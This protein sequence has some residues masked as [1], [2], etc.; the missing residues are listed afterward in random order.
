[1][2]RSPDGEERIM[3]NKKS[4]NRRQQSQQGGMSDRGGR[5]QSQQPSRGTDR[6]QSGSRSDS[7]RSQS[8]IS[9][10]TQQR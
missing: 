1:M 6:P 10:R 7:S 4:D 2:M 5:Q 3:A 8:N 9:H